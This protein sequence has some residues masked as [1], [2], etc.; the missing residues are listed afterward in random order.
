MATWC[1]SPTAERPS[2]HTTAG[3]VHSRWPAD[4]PDDHNALVQLPCS[5]PQRVGAME[6]VQGPLQ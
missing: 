4:I 3:V 5:L 6:G 2:N 1:S